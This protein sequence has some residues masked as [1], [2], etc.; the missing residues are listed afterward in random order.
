MIPTVT[1]HPVRWK[2][3]RAAGMT[4]GPSVRLLRQLGSRHAALVRAATIGPVAAIALL[5]AP[6]TERGPLVVVVTGTLVWCAIYVRNLLRHGGNWPGTRLVA[7]DVTIMA[8]VCVSTLCT[9]A[10]ES[11]NAGWVRL[12]ATFVCVVCQWHTGVLVGTAATLVV[13]GS[14]VSALAVAGASA[15]LLTAAIWIVVAGTLSR[16][17]WVLLE[18]VARTADRVMA[19]AAATR[20]AHRV[21]ET[22][23]AQER[24][25]AG[26]LHDT[27]A[28]TL[29]MVGTER[30]DTRW[31]AT[32]ARRDLE[33][34]RA[35]AQHP[36]ED[37]HL[38]M[39]LRDLVETLPLTGVFDG[40]ATVSVPPPVTCAVLDAAREALNNVVRHARADRVHVR[41]RGGS[42]WVRVT[43]AD[44]GCGF[45]VDTVP[46]TRR[47]VR[48][49]IRRRLANVGGSATITTRPHHGTT[50]ALEWR[51]E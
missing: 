19:E 20:R 31:L 4:D 11:N 42:G 24:E 48:E 44:D 7:A 12:L 37:A 1:L 39:A 50:V 49:S 41:L 26:A 36:R 33:L 43:V 10:V 32:Q 40:P 46:V 9:G 28:T 21:A 27:A 15:P 35:Y 30:P 3:P 34:L 47:G 16:I 23:R 17:V 45:D 38:A 51:G 13:T 22:I 8:G 6:A 25:F 18:R 5:R 2:R 29:L 14:L